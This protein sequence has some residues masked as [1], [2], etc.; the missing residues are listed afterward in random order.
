MKNTILSI[1]KHPKLLSNDLSLK[2]TGY[3][4]TRPQ[5]LTLVSPS[6]GKLHLDLA[7]LIA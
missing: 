3:K 7:N 5:I 1:T 4:V 6:N 2:P